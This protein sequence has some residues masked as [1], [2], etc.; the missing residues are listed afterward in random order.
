MK[1]ATLCICG[2]AFGT[3]ALKGRS[4]FAAGSPV[5]RVVVLLKDLEARIQADGKTE[6]TSYD[7]Y[8]CWCE[9]TSDRTAAA[10]HAAQDELRA[11]GQS[12]LKF[13]EEVAVL[14]AE[15]AET[16]GKI[17][18]NEKEQADETELRQRENAAYVAGANEMKDAI[19]ALQKAVQV[20]V[21]GTSL[22]QRESSVAPLAEASTAVRKVLQSLPTR[23][24]VKQ[25]NLTLLAA[26]ASSSD[27]AKQRYAPQSLTIQGILKDMYATFTS[28]L[29]SSTTEEAKANRDFEHF[30][31][32]KMEELAVLKGENKAREGKKA[33]A[34][35]NLAE[36]TQNYDD[37]NQQM[38]ADIVF[39]DA[40]KL[41]CQTKHE[42]WSTRSVL[43]DEELRGIAKALELLTSDNA[44]ELFAD[45]IK[46]G[47]ETKMSGAYDSGVDIAPAVFLQTGSRETA[48]ATAKAHALEKLNA[49]ARSAHS[50]RL[51]A[52]AATLR[53]SKVGQFDA[54]LKAIDDM[55]QT[56][57]DEDADDI[58]KRDQCLEEYQKINSTV[59]NVKWLIKENVA[60]ID[61]L[62]RLIEKATVE[63]EETQASIKE[64]EDQIKVI[65]DVR[66][67][68]HA[69]FLDAKAKDTDAIDLLMK[70]RDYL[71]AYYSN[72]SIDLG[73]IQGEV[74]GLALAQQ[75]GPPIFDV[76][77]DQA[78]EAALSGKGKRKN[79][80][81]GIVQI[82]T[83][84]IEDLHDEI[85][86]GMKE[87]HLAQT[88]YEKQLAAAEALK[89]DLITKKTNLE[90]TIGR[91]GMEKSEENRMEEVNKVD[92][93]N[94]LDYRA[95]IK[96]DCDW[97]IGA[98][99]HREQR[100]VA[101]MNGLVGA[102]EYLAGFATRS[103][104]VQEPRMPGSAFDD[105]TFAKIRFLGIRA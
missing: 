32:T 8:A 35:A 95:K 10:I 71:S 30:I 37:A 105:T 40:T 55:I 39:F 1:L 26:F 98:F 77:E 104:L 34:E 88:A 48:M 91:L 56:L 101:E 23:G 70:A 13:K 66:K 100:R 99:S 90:Q 2:L 38:K 11:L 59:A 52:L 45:A 36:A 81:K 102:K 96:P 76:S 67:N 62:T 4:D 29:K 46:A 19:A 53:E 65:G 61:K 25:E 6:T 80:A 60:K 73:P 58:A 79:E 89:A 50:L 92:L 16:S 3:M 94:E 86:N 42:E 33:E 87:E 44:R 12:I 17:Q 22:L 85:L 97:I 27:G 31:A 103:S 74:K 54:V 64:T 72:H 15:I 57:K 41:S 5:E 68:E 93:E 24:I 82:M 20:L 51:A 7:K 75:R 83:M 43:R 78:P 9:K 14:T 18:A 69:E 84:L 63:K 21:T 47:K 49:E 28:D